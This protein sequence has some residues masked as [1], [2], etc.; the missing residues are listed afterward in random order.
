M[1]LKIIYY[2]HGTTNDNACINYSYWKN[3]LDKMM[4]DNRE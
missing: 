3:A 1:S 2:V 4:D